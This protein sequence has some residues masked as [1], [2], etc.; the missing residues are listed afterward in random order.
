MLQ[1][2]KERSIFWTS[3]CYFKYH[4]SA[5]TEKAVGKTSFLELKHSWNDGDSSHLLPPSSNS[6]KQQQ[7]ERPAVTGL[8]EPCWWPDATF[9]LWPSWV[10]QLC[11]RLNRELRGGGPNCLAPAPRVGK[12]LGPLRN[13]VSLN[14]AATF[15][16]ANSSVFSAA[17]WMKI[18]GESIPERG[19]KLLFLM[20]P[21]F[22]H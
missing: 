20:N 16:A 6:N 1:E 4:E 13:E 22:S 8:Q 15:R 18:H 10:Q 9:A 14:E 5:E 21:S 12:S 11:L 17:S 2:P 19:L 3:L 7:R